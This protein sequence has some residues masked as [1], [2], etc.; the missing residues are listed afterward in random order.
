MTTSR[1]TTAE[2]VALFAALTGQ[3]VT[4]TRVIRYDQRI[5]EVGGYDEITYTPVHETT[6]GIVTAIDTHGERVTVHLEP[7]EPW[8]AD[9]YNG[10]HRQVHLT[11]SDHPVGSGTEFAVDKH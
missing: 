5:T 3:L 7:E 1:R 11:G 2:I 9:G 10:G 4:I 6:T 8:G